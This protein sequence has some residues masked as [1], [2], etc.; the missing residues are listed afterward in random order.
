[1]CGSYLLSV[2]DS[3]E[4]A[5]ILKA[6]ARRQAARRA[7]ATGVASGGAGIDGVVSGDDYS[8][9]ASAG[10]VF[11]D[12]AS[13][14]ETSA[15]V[16]SADAVMFP[17]RRVPVVWLEDGHHE[18]VLMH[19][20]LPGFDGGREIINARSETAAVK[21]L[22]SESLAHRRCVV[23][24]TGFFEWS[25]E[26]TRYR[27]NLPDRPEVYLAG[28]YMP[29]PDGDRCCILTRPA[30]AVVAPIHDRMPVVLGRDDL[31]PWLDDGGETA[32]ILEALAPLLVATPDTTRRK[33]D[34]NHRNTR[35][36]PEQPS[37]F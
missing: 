15:D 17:G 12:A 26:K 28:I 37:L 34:G 22:F 16:P 5:H 29:S 35:R 36:P 25:P 11:T 33:P 32:R 18:P 14:R 20:G 10:A 7:A 24:T 2:E 13:A 4:I 9:R 30:S 3:D 8:A 1:M 6:L 27:F 23:P 31:A 21:P 19:W